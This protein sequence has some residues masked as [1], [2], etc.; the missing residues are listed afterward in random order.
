MMTYTS[1]TQ[2]PHEKI[3]AFHIDSS[4]IQSIKNCFT[5][6]LSLLKIYHFRSLEISCYLKSQ[7]TIKSTF[8]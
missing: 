7:N 5:K 3:Q 8:I 6:K 4:D 1:L 2:N